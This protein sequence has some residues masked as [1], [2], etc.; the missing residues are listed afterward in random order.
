MSAAVLDL[1][2]ADDPQE[3]AGCRILKKREKKGFKICC[4]QVTDEQ[5]RRQSEEEEEERGADEAGRGEKEEDGRGVLQKV[6]SSPEA[7]GCL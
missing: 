2:D 7:S 1:C 4:P 6:V 3:A 5:R